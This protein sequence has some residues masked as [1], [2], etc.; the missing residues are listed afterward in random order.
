MRFGARVAFVGGWLLYP[1]RISRTFLDYR[2]NNG[3]E[4]GLSRLTSFG[5]PI[6]IEQ[7]VTFEKPRDELYEMWEDVD[8]VAQILAPVVTVEI[9]PLPGDGCGQIPH[10][11]G[12]S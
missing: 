10:I 5:E 3:V 11:W 2:G 8:A 1:I 7:S 9:N 6:I 4:Q 12:G